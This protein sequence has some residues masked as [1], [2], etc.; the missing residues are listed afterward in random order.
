MVN[1]VIDYRKITG[2]IIITILWMCDFL[3]IKPT[4]VIDWTGDGTS[5]TNLQLLI[6]VIFLLILV[7]YHI[8]YH[9][10]SETTKLSWTSV[11]TIV[12]LSLILFYPFKD[13]NNNSAGAVGFFT[14]VGG[15]AVCVLWVHFFAD[16]IV[17]KQ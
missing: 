15:L 12:W 14:L 2:A 5:L 7:F 1:G 10:N 16:E 11:L 9:S 8:F 3:F 17:V 13:P 6:A 4:L